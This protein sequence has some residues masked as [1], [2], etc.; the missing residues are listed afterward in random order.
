MAG[1][2]L[3]S[4]VSDMKKMHIRIKAKVC[5]DRLFSV[6]V[7]STTDKVIAM[8]GDKWGRLG[9]WDIVSDTLTSA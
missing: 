4:F 6:A 5:K 3:H 9:L 8:A 1:S 2:S 7:H